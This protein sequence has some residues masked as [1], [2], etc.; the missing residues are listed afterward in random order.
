MLVHPVYYTVQPFTQER[1]T[2]WWD[3]PSL[4][5]IQWVNDIWWCVCPLGGQIESIVKC[6][7][8]PLC[9]GCG[10]RTTNCN[11]DAAAAPWHLCWPAGMMDQ[12]TAAL[13]QL[14]HSATSGEYRSQFTQR[15]T[16][17]CHG[18]DERRGWRFSK[19]KY[20]AGKPSW[21]LAWREAS[22]AS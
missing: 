3:N 8:M 10:W 7:W 1:M 2:A 22:L 14:A 15:K 18:E 5:S 11:R 19:V 6:C 21:A 17:A 9:S 12:I 20:M 4:V 13:R 16:H